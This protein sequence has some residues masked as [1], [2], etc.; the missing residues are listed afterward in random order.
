MSKKD[1]LY[2]T[3]FVPNGE[4]GVPRVFVSINPEYFSD[5]EK[6]LN[7]NLEK[8]N[9]GIIALL[10]ES[11]SFSKGNT[12]E[13]GYKNACGLRIV[14]EVYE[15]DFPL[16]AA[17]KEYVVHTLE[18][19]LRSLNE[20]SFLEKDTCQS[21]EVAVSIGNSECDISG[22]FFPRFAEKIRCHALHNKRV[23]CRSDLPS[24]EVFLGQI[25]DS[26]KRALD[27][28]SLSR[29]T[30]S[31][32]CRVHANIE[33]NR[34]FLGY[35]DSTEKSADLSGNG[36]SAFMGSGIQDSVQLLTVFVGLVSMVGLVREYS[37]LE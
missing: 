14:D 11:P 19:V 22:R 1:W 7:G 17:I 34:M 28:L 30:Y 25:T 4:R 9:D 36:D 16:R 37:S 33:S 29:Q 6:M 13:Y 27:A 8:H 18:V 3:H 21:M 5:F 32:G 35:K 24:E 10:G 31:R 26:M 23:A 2:E 20:V 12:G 15:I